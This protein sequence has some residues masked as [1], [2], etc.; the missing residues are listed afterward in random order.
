M[1]YYIYY[2]YFGGDLPDD[3]ITPIDYTV[4][5]SIHNDLTEFEFRLEGIKTEQYDLN[6]DKSRYYIFLGIVEISKLT[7]SSQDGSFKQEF[8]DLST[9]TRAT[10]ENMYG[11]SFDDWNFDGYIDV[12]LWQYEGGTMRNS[13]HYYWLWDNVAGAFAE[14]TQL[15][16]MS[17]YSTVSVDTEQ[18]QITSFTRYGPE[19]HGTGYYEYIDGKYVTV[20]TRE[21][22]YELTEGEDFEYNHRVIIKELIGGELIITEDYYDYDNEY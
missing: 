4:T 9:W 1:L 19:G 6:H 7:I 20:K 3:I 2:N 22:L 8:T 15:A 11:L 16:E 17:D 18:Q 14:N 21:D 12:S 5:M 13:P 10:E